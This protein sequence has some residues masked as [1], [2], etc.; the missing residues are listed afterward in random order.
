M[1]RGASSEGGVE[2]GKGT[3]VESGDAV[4]KDGDGDVSMGGETDAE[5][6]RSDHERS[7]SATPAV[8]LPGL[9][10]L[11]T[12]RKYHMHSALVC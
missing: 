6:R 1:N 10:K 11:P 9:F 12:K 8:A 5:R 7:S 4:R 3:P 2:S